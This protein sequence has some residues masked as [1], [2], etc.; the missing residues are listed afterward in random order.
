MNAPL[1]RRLKTAYEILVNPAE[2]TENVGENPL[3]SSFSGLA[4]WVRDV[5]VTFTFSQF[6]IS[7]LKTFELQVIN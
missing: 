5:E 4:D 2:T 7:S 1:P 6:T 3:A